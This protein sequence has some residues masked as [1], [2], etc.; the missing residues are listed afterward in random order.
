[1]KSVTTEPRPVA[2]RLPEGTSSHS[3]KS[4]DN[5]KQKERGFSANT[6]TSNHG[7][8]IYSIFQAR[9]DADG[10]KNVEVINGL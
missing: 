4:F 3:S 2:C 7:V 6:H 9:L 8:L 5:T 1:M 10:K